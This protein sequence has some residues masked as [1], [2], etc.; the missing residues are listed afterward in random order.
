[1]SVSALT[2][3]ELEGQD[4]HADQVASVDALVGFGDHRVDTL[5]VG[6][7]GSPITG[8]TGSVLFTGQDDELFASIL[9]LLGGVK[10]GHLL[11]RGHVDGGGTDLGHHLVDEAH[12]GEGTTGH[13]LV[14]TS[15]GTVGVEVLG[16]DVA[17][18]EV[19]GGGGILGDLTSG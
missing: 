8:G 3:L 13:D 10:D 14:V 11:T 17:L 15:A 1:M 4:T 16:G 18:G 2:I 6:A 12:V 19:A 7:L 5:K 9:I